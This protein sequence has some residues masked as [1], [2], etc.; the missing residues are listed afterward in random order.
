MCAGLDGAADPAGQAG[1]PAQ[2]R[3]AAGDAAAPSGRAQLRARPRR[4]PPARAR[5]GVLHGRQQRRAAAQRARAT[6]LRR[7]ACATPTTAAATWSS[8]PPAGAEALSRA[9]RAQEAIEDDV[10]A[11]ARPRR[12]RHPVAAADPRALRRGAGRASLRHSEQR[13]HAHSAYSAHAPRRSRPERPSA[14]AAT[15]TVTRA[16]GSSREERP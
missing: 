9:E 14:A 13:R 4:L 10:S 5:R 6:R 3:R 2:Q 7:R 16:G 1:L 8:S 12:A 15:P 11:G